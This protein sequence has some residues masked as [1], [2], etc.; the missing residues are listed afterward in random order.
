MSTKLTPQQLAV[1]E[2]CGGDLLVSAAAG[3]G[4]TKVLV[5]KLMREICDNKRN[6]TDFIIIT[7]TQKA[8]SELRMKIRSEIAAR[9]AENPGDKH[10]AAQ[11][12]L[13]YGATISTV[14]SAC[15]Q[16]LRNYSA[17]IGLTS[18]FRV[19]E[20]REAKELRQ[21]CM[22]DL[23]EEAY[24]NIDK[25]PNIKAFLLQ[26]AAGRNGDKAVPAMV[27]HAYDTVLSHPWPNEWIEEILRMLNVS[28]ETDAAETIWGAYLVGSLQDYVQTQIELV[29][30]CQY[31]LDR[32]PVL[33]AAYGPAVA[34]DKAKMQTILASKSWRAISAVVNEKWAPL[35]PIRQKKD[36]PVEYDTVLQQVFKGKR[37]RYKKAVDSKAKFIAENES[38]HLMEDL[39]AMAPAVR[40]LFEMIQKF[41]RKYAKK[42]AEHNLLD[43]SDLEHKTIE[44]L[45]EPNSGHAQT[46][47]ARELQARYVGIYIDEYQDT[48]S[49]QETIFQAISSNNRV[50]VGDVK[51]SIYQFRLADPEIFLSHFNAYRDYRDASGDEPRRITLS[52][53]FR[54]RPEILAATNSVMETCMSPAVGGVRYVGEEIL[55]AGKEF[56]APSSAVV[57]LVAIDM[58][59]DT[60][61]DDSDVRKSNLKSDTEAKYIASRIGQ[62]LRD[63]ETIRES[64]G[65]ERPVTPSDCA[66]LLRSGKNSAHHYAA[67]LAELGIKAI[68]PKT[69][70]L[71]DTPEVASLHC[72]LQLIDNPRQDIPLVAVLASPLFGFTADDLAQIRIRAK[73]EGNVDTFYDALL[74]SKEH[75]KK[76]NWFLDTLAT[77]REEAKHAPI[78]QIFRS[79]LERT[80]A[81][82]VFG[83]MQS[84]DQRMENI[85]AYAEHI[86]R[87][88]TNSGGNLFRFLASVEAMRAQDVSLQKPNTAKGDN[89][90]TI[91]TIH[92]AKGLEY[93]IVFLADMSRRFNSNELKDSVLL[94][95]KYGAGVQY[96]DLERTARWPTLARSAISARK[97]EEEK[98]EELRIL[99]VAMTRAQHKL[100][101]CH[102]ESNLT[103]TVSRLADMASF[104]LSPSVS[105]SV[106][107]PG[108]WV[109][110]TAL[111]RAEATALHPYCA[112]AP[113]T[114]TMPFPW[115]VSVLNVSEIGGEHKTMAELD[116]CATEDDLPEFDTVYPELDSREILIDPGYTY[117]WMPAVNT[118]SKIGVSEF[119]KVGMKSDA[120]S[121]KAI[122]CRR[123]T[124]VKEEKVA[125]A[126][127]RGTATHDFLSKCSFP[128]C[129]E[130][131]GAGVDQEID[132]LVRDGFMSQ[133]DANAVL[134]P[135]LKALFTS[136]VGKELAAI[137]AKEMRREFS[138]TLLLPASE[139]NPEIDPAD[140]SSQFLLQ[141]V[142]DAFYVS[143]DGLHLYDFKTDWI[144]SAGD[145]AEKSADHKPQLDTYAMA[146]EKIYQLPVVEKSIIYVRTGHKVSL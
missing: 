8:A 145:E 23:I 115:S 123:P 39:A 98:S 83:A 77:L 88:E 58:Q 28:P 13:I 66:I 33:S 10:I 111:N 40:G 120:E 68:V 22:D 118:R 99:Y 11:M 128:F 134:R 60:S 14:H 81:M 130:H 126:A 103:R 24:S 143:K 133:L 112:T 65:A 146:L 131:G 80:D 104:P 2:N 142:I 117:P 47:T 140:T 106:S 139:L 87:F 94:H 71:L 50:M 46:D 34:A 114:I 53:N 42:K 105:Q 55:T 38:T 45:Y 36:A 144:E 122:T 12:T 27:F 101:M 78:S 95:P 25:S 4:K 51:Q 135:A 86:A 32:D 52:K 138:F 90:V 91:T 119:V 30:S 75:S 109:L 76:V 17:Q 43:F 116:T 37:D 136:E 9:L 132:R 127:E 110:L 84:G 93:P 35:K 54:S 124:F 69:E 108:E 125:T 5:E 85:N 72:M 21:M 113:R 102:T 59:S 67:A 137:P 26:L 20:E 96:V 56:P 57:E 15:A 129:A 48:N 29:D 31:L 1:V 7:Y 107:S 74:I 18:D 19:S 63:G 82:D 89:A 100:I 41:S 141:G 3:S 73:H 70:N 61:D 64:D 79:V 62:M 6:I 97:L 44:L 92:T 16:F 121:G 49:V